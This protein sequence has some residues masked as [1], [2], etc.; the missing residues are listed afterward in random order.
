MRRLIESFR[1]EGAFIQVPF[2]TRVR[3]RSDNVLISWEFDVR[4]RTAEIAS[5]LPSFPEYVANVVG[6]SDEMVLPHSSSCRARPDQFDE[7]GYFLEPGVTEC[8]EFAGVVFQRIRIHR[9]EAGVF[10]HEGGVI[11]AQRGPLVS[12]LNE[13]AVGEA[14]E[15]RG[16]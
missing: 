2:F 7:R 6:G 1:H 11:V 4:L 5:L 13:V 14:V 8:V 15:N 10:G 16:H 12:N 3:G 9:V